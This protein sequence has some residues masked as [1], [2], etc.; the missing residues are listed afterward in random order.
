VNFSD[1]LK[2]LT[3]AHEELETLGFDK[4]DLKQFEVSIFDGHINSMKVV[5][6]NYYIKDLKNE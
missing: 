6:S 5:Y 3:F 1:V 4:E 2:A